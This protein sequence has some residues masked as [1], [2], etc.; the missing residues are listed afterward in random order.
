MP[1]NLLDE[2][3]RDRRWCQG[4]LINFRLFLAKGLHPAHRAVFVTGV[5]AYLSA[6]LWFLF[7]VLSTVLLAVHTLI[8]PKYFVSPNQLFPLWPEWHPSRAIGLFTRDRDAAVP[9]EDPQRR[10]DRDARRAALR[11]R[12][13][14]GRAA[15][16][17]EMVFSMLLAPVR[18]LFHTQFVVAALL[19][20]KLSWKSP[21]REDA[22]TTWGEAFR[23]HGL[24]TLLGLAWL[25]ARLLAESVVPLVAAAGRRRAHGVDSDL[26]VVEPRLARP[27]SSRRAP[28]PDSRGI[29]SAARAATHA[30][31]FPPRAAR[32]RLRRRGRRSAAQRDRVRGRRRAH[33]AF[34]C[35]PAR[36]TTSSSSAR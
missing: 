6:P 29:V 18:M 30:P 2:L 32:C 31:L 14:A 34:G 10:A 15:C 9:A 36:A 1:P 21:P 24:H 3:K 20:W 28:V 22:E 23:R 11:R 33:A 17:V 4:N 16:C 13:A 7:L 27:Q 26:G 5:M 19:G 8:E 25:G 12:A 35:D